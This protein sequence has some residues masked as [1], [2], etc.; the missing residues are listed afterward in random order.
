MGITSLRSSVRDKIPRNG[1][2]G[3]T[4]SDLLIINKIDLAEYVGADLAV[5]ERDTKRMRGEKPAV[6]TDLR[7]SK[8]LEDVISWIQR[9]LLFEEDAKSG[10]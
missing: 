3:I 4:R 9:E 2:P 6:F 5:M 10:G 7:K 1:G 8:G